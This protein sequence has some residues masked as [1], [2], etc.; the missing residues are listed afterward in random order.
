MTLF[1][2]ADNDIADND[3][4]DNDIAYNVIAYKVIGPQYTLVR[5]PS[6]FMG[7]FLN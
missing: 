7:G 6:T 1:P 3:S 2:G 4:A 5:V